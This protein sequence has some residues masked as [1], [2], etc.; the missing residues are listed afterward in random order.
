M[1]YW[2]VDIIADRDFKMMGLLIAAFLLVMAFLG[3]LLWHST[4]ITSPASF[5][6]QTLAFSPPVFA[7]LKA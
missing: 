3:G 1:W 4:L 7:P 6:H 2:L 5:L